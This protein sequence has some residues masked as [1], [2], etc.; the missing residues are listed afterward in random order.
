MWAEA[1]ARIENER[2]RALGGGR[3]RS[4]HRFRVRSGG[5]ATT[6]E[7][8]EL[9]KVV[10]KY[11]GAI[12]ATHMR[13][14]DEKAIEAVKE[15]IEIGEKAGVP[16]HFSHHPTRYPFHG[17][18]NELL[19]LQEDARERGIDVTSDTYIMSHNMS[20]LGALIPHWVHEGGIEKFVERLKDPEIR[21]K[22]KE[23]K[24][25][26]Q[27]HFRDRKWDKVILGNNTK[28]K[29]LIGN[30][31]AEIAKIK[32]YE[33]PWEMA[34][35]MMIEEGGPLVGIYC[36]TFTDEDISLCLKHPTS[37]AVGSDVSV[38]APYGVLSEKLPHPAAYGFYPMFFRK[39]VREMNVL[40]LEEAVRKVSSFPARAKV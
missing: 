38:S 29:E 30:N 6:E 17:R 2:A 20:G 23:Y 36:N 34:I 11:P 19:K 25:P 24:N 12:Y 22:I 3:I 16:V 13:Q 15:G 33:D 1:R 40:R 5:N 27:K 37:M 26:Q 21:K 10:A 28:N 35:D 32:G 39:F 31:F 8:I 18:M 14:R 7:I 4:L 9:A